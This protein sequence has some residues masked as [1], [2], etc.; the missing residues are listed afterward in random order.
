[1]LLILTRSF[2]MTWNS[3]QTPLICDRLAGHLSRLRLN[4]DAVVEQVREAVANAVGRTVAG[5]VGEAVYDALLTHD[6]QSRSLLRS[7]TRYLTASPSGRE[8]DDSAWGRDADG[9]PWHDPYA[10][11]DDLSSFD[12]PEPDDVPSPPD[13]P[14]RGRGGRAVAVGLQAT[15][16][17]LRRRPDP[18][19]LRAAL[20]V[21]A[22]AGLAVL[23]GPGSV[24]AD[25]LASAL[26][27]VY[28][29]DLVRLASRL[30]ER[31]VSPGR[32]AW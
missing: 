27:L 28:V 2:F 7:T 32:T 1:M 31:N 15:A 23:V 10:Y 24:A 29:L 17:W 6:G 25:L 12:D 8:R 20:A 21:G 22:V 9:S 14:R 16:W 19:A 3:S 30:L 5:A 26:A 13:E 18:I 4:L 11:D